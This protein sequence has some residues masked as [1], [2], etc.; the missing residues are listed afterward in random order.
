MHSLPFFCTKI[1]K[2]MEWEL[3]AHA[4]DFTL[5][6]CAEAGILSSWMDLQVAESEW[7]HGIDM[8]T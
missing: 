1:I 6:E 8:N 4:P 7:L 3:E 5:Q 2:W